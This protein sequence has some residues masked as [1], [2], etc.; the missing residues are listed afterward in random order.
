ME[1]KKAIQD[2]YQG[3]FAHCYGCGYKNEE[4]LYIKSYWED[5]VCVCRFL[6]DMKYSGGR[7][8]IIYGG[9]IASIIDCHSAATAAAFRAMELGLDLE[10]DNI[11]RFVTGRLSV[12]YIKPAPFEKELELRAEIKESKGRKVVVNTVL[13]AG[14]QLCARGECVMVQI[15]D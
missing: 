9:L 5:D 6:P 2:Y 4:G 1:F 13:S 15:R 8:D 10:T 7:K 14:G 12:D 11:P 3:E